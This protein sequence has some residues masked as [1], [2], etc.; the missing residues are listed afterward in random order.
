MTG[1]AGQRRID[2]NY[3]KKYRIPIPSLKKQKELLDQIKY[4]QSLV[5]PSKTLIEV[6]TSKINTKIKEVWGE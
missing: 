5:E 2:I 6:F 1:T 3:V 4:E